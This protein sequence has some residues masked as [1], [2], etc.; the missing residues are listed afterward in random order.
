MVNGQ[1]SLIFSFSLSLSYLIF[2]SLLP[3]LLLLQV[4]WSKRWAKRTKRVN[5][6]EC[7]WLHTD[8]SLFTFGGNL[9]Y[10]LELRQHAFRYSG[11]HAR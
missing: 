5:R 1:H 11:S 7:S 9:K 6:V 4:I 3:L 2:F 8:L 10:M